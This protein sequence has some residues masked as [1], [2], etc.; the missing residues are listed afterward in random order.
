MDDDSQHS[1]GGNARQRRYLRRHP[2]HAVSRAETPAVPVGAATA[3]SIS[4]EQRAD[5]APAATA[6]QSVFA[7]LWERAW[8]LPVAVPGGLVLLGAGVTAMFSNSHIAATACYFIGLAWLTGAIVKQPEVKS[9]V[10]RRA[11]IWALGVLVFVGS[12]AWDR[13]VYD[14]NHPSAPPQVASDPPYVQ[15]KGPG[16]RMDVHVPVAS[17]LLCQ[18]LSAEKEIEC[19]CPRPL[20][21]KLRSLPAPSDNN[22]A[23][24]VDIAAS[25]EPIYR[26]RIF[27][28]TQVRSGGEFVVSPYGD[29]KSASAVGGMDYDPYSLI[30]QSSAPQR[31]Y[32][33]EVHSSEGLRLKCINQ[34]N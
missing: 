19:L 29:G 2:E 17:S 8:S 27:A 9:H 11:V 6:R 14:A 4:I 24:E 22:Y 10:G 15:P 32:K 25:R 26:L 21:Y 33:I 5:D 23:T 31:E 34:E 28:R 3:S 12:L 20:P 7:W 13:R 16:V 18:G 1:L 30:A